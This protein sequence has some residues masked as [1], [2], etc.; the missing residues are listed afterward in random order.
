M[1]Q[2]PAGWYPDP[3][4]TH[5]GRQRYWDGTAW[6]AH[7]HDPVPP[8]PPA[9]PAYPEPY[10]QG[11]PQAYAP[12]YG[13]TY[14]PA[15]PQP[16]TTPDGQPLSGWWRRVL[17]QLLD[18]LILSPVLL[19]VLAV[20]VATRWQEI[21]TWFDEY[22]SA[23]DAGNTPPPAPDLFQPFSTQMLAFAA[24][25]T[26][27]LAIY[28]LGFWRWKQATPGKLI[29][30][31]RIRRRETPGPMPWSTMLPRFLFVQALALAAYAPWIG[32]LFVLAGLLDYLWPLWDSRNQALHD[33]V[34]RT[35]VV[36]APAAEQAPGAPGTVD[37][38]AAGLP[39]RW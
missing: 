26:I 14:A 39:R 21:S 18:G 38:T 23:L 22:S 33:K 24:A 7:V 5:P 32:F 16:R 8:A 25:W 35:N 30:G 29:V 11:H 1:T 12:S 19:G 6:T 2:I 20:F 15:L 37:L 27:V 36:V 31:V 13:A 10:T 17:A 28:T 9:Y 34:A 3:A 4:Q